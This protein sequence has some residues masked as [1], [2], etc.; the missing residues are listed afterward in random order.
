VEGGHASAVTGFRAQ[1]VER[2]GERL[3][4]LAEDGRRLDPVDEVVVLTGLRPDLSFLSEVRPGHRPDR[5]RRPGADRQL[6]KPPRRR[7]RRLRRRRGRSLP[8]PGLRCFRLA[9]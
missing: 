5:H 1:A 8:E 9:L 7:K 6:L 3:V 2:D 4:L